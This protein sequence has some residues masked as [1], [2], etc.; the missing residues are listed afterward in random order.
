M[1][2]AEGTVAELLLLAR[3]TMARLLDAAALSV[4]VHESLPEPVIDALLQEMP[5]N[6]AAR[7]PE[8]NV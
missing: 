2:T 4:T 3:L 1:V 7:A 6:V 8:T 5:L